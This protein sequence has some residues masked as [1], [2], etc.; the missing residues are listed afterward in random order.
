LEQAVKDVSASYDAL[1]DL[2]E[3]IERFLNRLDI[4]T[5]IE[6]TTPMIGIL[7]KIMSEILSAL[8]LAT[9]EVKRGRMSESCPR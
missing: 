7:V 9:K 3:S 2:F 5:R 6:L 1:V 4:Y 8:A